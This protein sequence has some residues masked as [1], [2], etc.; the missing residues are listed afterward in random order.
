[1]KVLYLTKYT[2][3]GASSRMRSFQY[4][5]YLESSDLKITVRPFF[6]DTYL[7]MLYSGKKSLM[8]VLLAYLKRFFVIFTV[9]KFDRIVIEYE[10]FPYFPAWFEKLFYRLGVKYIVDYD[11]AIFHNYDLNSNK[12]IRKLLG[13]KIDQIMKFSSVVVAGNQYLANRAKSAGA[14]KILIIPTVID[15]ENYKVKENY[16][17]E[18]FRIGW[19]GS[20]S[21]YRYIEEIKEHLII[22]AHQYKAEIVIVGASTE[23]RSKPPFLYIPWEKNT[24]TEWIRSFDVGLMPLDD[25]PWSKGK[26]SFKLIQYMACGVPV[27]ASPVGMNKEVVTS[28]NGFLADTP[29][30][31]YESLSKYA[32]SPL[33]RDQYGKEGRKIVEK[34]YALQITAKIWKQLLMNNDNI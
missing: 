30:E 27:I 33:L 10:I 24:E 23:S 1:M 14:N 32:D 18:K 34:K 31:W 25:T 29:K 20:P 5:S 2:A 15:L 13:N 7:D 28:L 4:F 26:C 11:D 22:F 19:I 6:N 9:L 12:L 16:A 21:T 8:I 3:K 17:T